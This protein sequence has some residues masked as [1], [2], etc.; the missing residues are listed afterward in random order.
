MPHKL[1]S[2][3]ITKNIMSNQISVLE[4]PIVDEPVVP[5]K[6]YSSFRNIIYYDQPHKYY[7]GDRNL[8][9]CTTFLGL[10]KPKFETEVI[11][12]KYAKSRGLDKDDVIDEWDFK[13]DFSCLKGT[14][15]HKYAEDYVNNKI[16]PYDGAPF[17]KLFGLDIMKS[18][19]D[20]LKILYE[21]FYNDSQ[22]NLIPIKSEMIVGDEELGI[23][24][25]VD[26]IYYNKKAGEFQIYDYKSNKKIGTKSDYNQRFKH[27]VSHL[28]MCEL[29]S[30]SLQLEMY[31]YILERN[32][33]IKIGSCYLVWLFEENDS[34]K[35][36]KTYDMREEIL[37]MVDFA[38]KNKWI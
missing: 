2:P 34:Y 19:F 4:K 21:K 14:L 27:P 7:V 28:E 6:F 20:R 12:E 8:I 10:F 32:T 35:I 22:K 24:G 26:Q 17:V 25:C 3:A 31:K 1:S 15:I 38:Q 11:A 33:G 36:Y 23:A 13:R 18:K 9:S 16:F 29:N 5:L 30:Y 37:S